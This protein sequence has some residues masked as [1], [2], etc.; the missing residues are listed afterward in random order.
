M[1]ASASGARATWASNSETSV[2]AATAVL[3]RDRVRVAYALGTIFVFNV[4][5]VLAYPP[6]GRL[7]GLS[8]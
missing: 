8:Q 7:L 1:T 3:K 4:V 5:A 2:A 6:L